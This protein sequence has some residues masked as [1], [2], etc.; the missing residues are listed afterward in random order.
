[1]QRHKLLPYCYVPHLPQHATRA[2]HTHA[3]RKRERDRSIIITGHLLAC[4]HGL[5][6]GTL[7]SACFSG[8]AICFT[9]HI[10]V[11]PS[12]VT[13]ALSLFHF[14][15]AQSHAVVSPSLPDTAM[16]L[17]TSSKLQYRKK[18]KKIKRERVNK[19]FLSW[20]PRTAEAEHIL[21]IVVSTW[22]AGLLC[23]LPF[24]P[25]IG[26]HI[27]PHLFACLFDSSYR[28]DAVSLPLCV[29]PIFFF[30]ACEPS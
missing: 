15:V 18:Q 27:P 30:F 14:L 22:K 2:T 19:S 25:A 28:N 21:L 16:Q 13:R 23:P 8:V 20:V 7:F 5:F 6:N 26:N 10:S 17:T 4:V 11:P 3:Q 24:C 29:H 9:S 12:A 1:M